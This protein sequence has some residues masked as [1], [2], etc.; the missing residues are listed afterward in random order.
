MTNTSVI[1]KTIGRPTLKAAISSAK[2]EGFEVIVVSDGT[3]VD[4][5][6]A[7]R[8]VNLGKRWG[9]Y[10]GMAA[11]VGA[12]LAE[13]EFITFLDDDDQFMSG[14]GDI[15]R[16]KLKEDPSVDLWVGG[17]RFNTVI[18]VYDQTTGKRK[19]ASQDL[20]TNRNL[21]VVPGNVAMPTYRASI[22]SKLPFTD[23][24]APD[25]QNLTDFFHIK[26]CV[27]HGYKLDWFG[28][29]IYLVRPEAGGINGEGK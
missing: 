16:A 17:V 24:V 22:F 3:E 5:Q 13:T 27:S 18:E 21:G 28:D 14:A 29:V 2:R 9:F 4:A 15:I 23:T 12:A 6:D 11:N 8:Y 7:D 19:V 25:Q 20:C 1:I 10:G 26:S